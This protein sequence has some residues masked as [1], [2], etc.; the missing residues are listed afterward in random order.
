MKIQVL[1]NPG[2]FQT[3]ENFQVLQ[4]WIFFK[5]STCGLH[6]K[7]EKNPGDKLKKNPGLQELKFF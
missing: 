7:P 5:V 1:R 6:N 3:L 2:L 4:T